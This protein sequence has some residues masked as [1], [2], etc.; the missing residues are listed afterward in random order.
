MVGI[1]LRIRLGITETPVFQKVLDE[2]RVEA[3]PSFRHYG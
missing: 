3:W 1:G 2:E